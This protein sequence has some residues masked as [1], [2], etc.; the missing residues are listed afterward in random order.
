M[1]YMVAVS[2]KWMV[3][4]DAESACAAEH[5]ILDT[6]ADEINNYGVITGAQAFGPKE[7]KTAFFFE[8]LATCET[9][10]MTELASKINGLISIIQDISSS[11]EAENEIEDEMMELEI[12]I[13][14]LERRHEELALARERAHKYTSQLMV[15]A[16]FKRVELGCNK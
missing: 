14:E 6:F 16:D 5:I 3:L 2:N 13:A 12:E 10:S 15:K 11:K 9:I 4:V 8:M 1:K 7:M